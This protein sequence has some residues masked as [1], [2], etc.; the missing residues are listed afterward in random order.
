MFG[1]AFLVCPVTE[2]GATSRDVYLPAGTWY[3]FWTGKAYPGNTTIESAAT[4]DTMPLFVRAGSTVPMGPI[5][6][7]SGEGLTAP[8][9]LRIYP[10]KDGGFTM[11]SDDG[12]GYAYES[13]AY[14]ETPITWDDASCRLTLGARKGSAS[15]TP[16]ERTFHVVRVGNDKGNGL[17][18][19]TTPDAVL[20]YDGN[21]T[22]VT[23]RAATR[24]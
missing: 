9:E 15:F 12:D 21:S 18:A 20:P 8:I 14:G 23:L 4:I 3:D 7:H 5:V 11:Y 22:H 24:P 19:T 1:P 2:A 10:G 13:G 16:E 17:A 6:Q